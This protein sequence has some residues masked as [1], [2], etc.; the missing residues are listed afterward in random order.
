MSELESEKSK[1]EVQIQRNEFSLKEIPSLQ[2]RVKDQE[3]EID[4]LIKERDDLSARIKQMDLSKRS[5][6]ATTDRIK[7]LER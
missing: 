4:K 6:N 5:D 7:Y 1:L 2:K 3:S